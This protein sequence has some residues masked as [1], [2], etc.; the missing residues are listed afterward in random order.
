M[1]NKEELFLN[2]DKKAIS[3]EKEGYEKNSEFWTKK[4]DE[5]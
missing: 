2:N 1:S 3:A 5:L 4:G